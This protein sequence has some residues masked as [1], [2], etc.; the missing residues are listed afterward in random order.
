[1]QNMKTISLSPKAKQ[2]QL[3]EC[4]EPHL[5]GEHEIKVRVCSVGVCGT[6]R[7]LIVGGR[8]LAPPGEAQLILGHE[9]VGQVVEVGNAVTGFNKGD[10]AVVSVRRGC[11]S[12]VECSKGNEDLCCSGNYTERGIKQAHGFQAQYVVEREKYVMKVPAALG[13]LGVL[14]EPISVVE[15]AVMEPLKIQKNRLAGWGCESYKQRKAL[16]LGLG[17]IGLLA[18]MILRL[19]GWQV[20]GVGRGPGA[21]RQ[22]LLEKMGAVYRDNTQCGP[23]DF[24][25]EATGQ[26]ALVF[27]YLSV[28]GNNGIYA[29]TS[30]PEPGEHLTFDAGQAVQD[31][32]LRNQILFGSV[33]ANRE[34]WM[35]GIADLEQARKLWPGLLDQMITRRVPY[36]EYAQAFG[37]RPKGDI[38]TVIDWA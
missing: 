8:A 14:A 24:M 5:Q 19:R 28:L 20:Y 35:Q 31:I 11:G 9:M 7:E 23:V 4:Q 16:V 34:H 18:V 1:M 27:P 22:Q 30:V 17:P 29:L 6:D 32:V 3:V 2:V 15:K 37:P 10:W 12:C 33:N 21:E 13:W 26:A 38:K 25:L 36:T